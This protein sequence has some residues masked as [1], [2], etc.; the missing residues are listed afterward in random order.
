V[1]DL[2]LILTCEHGGNRVPAGLQHLFEGH[3]ELLESHRG[4]DP[5][6][7]ELARL[8]Q[9]QLDAP[10]E[11]STITRLLVEL[12][13]SQRHRALF[14]M[15]TAKVDP[16]TR[17]ALLA[18][19]YFPYRKAVEERIR[20]A[21]EAGQRVVHVSVHSFTPVLNSEVR[22]ADV[23]W[24]YDPR[25]TLEREFCG[26]WLTRLQ[27]RMPAL[28][29]RRNYPYLGISDG[30]TT[31]LRRVFDPGVYAGIELEVN[32]QWPLGDRCKWRSLQQALAATLGETLQSYSSR[33]ALPSEALPKRPV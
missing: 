1:S 8:M 21:I 2:R 7:L 22:R 9:R 16:P 13:R 19:Y 18:R 26:E 32:Q 33:A 28:R 29:L 31:A 23:G 10:L 14:S 24:L 6:A 30:F 4:Y 25:R 15:V 20:A 17:Q 3:R 27:S 12:N 5:G 11:F